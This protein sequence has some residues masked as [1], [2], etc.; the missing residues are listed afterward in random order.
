[1]YSNWKAKNP[2]MPDG[3]WKQITDSVTVTTFNFIRFK[4][5]IERIEEAASSSIFSENVEIFLI[6]TH[7][8][9]FLV[10]LLS[11]SLPFLAYFLVLLLL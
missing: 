2:N 6:F 8:K 1:M 3:K 10:A 11:L 7:F 4:Q 5:K 9:P